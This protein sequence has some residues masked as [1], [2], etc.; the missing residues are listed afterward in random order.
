[1]AIQARQ[2]NV[3][4]FG[5]ILVALWDTLFWVA[6]FGIVVTQMTKFWVFYEGH[7]ER[8]AHLAL[9][10]TIFISDFARRKITPYRQV[11]SL[12]LLFAVLSTS[13]YFWT[14]RLTIIT[15]QGIGT[16]PDI[17]TMGVLVFAA[18]RLSKTTFGWVFPIIAIISILYAMY[19]QLLPGLFHGPDLGWHR[20]GSRFSSEMHGSLLIFT[21]NYLW[22]LVFWGL[23]LSVSGVNIAVMKAANYLARVL[24]AG[25]AMICLVA[26]ASA[27]SFTGA[28]PTNTLI[29]GPIT[30]PAMKRAG[31][32]ANEAAAVEALASHGSAIT[33]PIMGTVAFIMATMLGVSYVNIMIM[34]IPAATL[35]YVGILVY[36]YAHFRRNSYRISAQIDVSA[37]S[38]VSGWMTF[39]SALMG[40]IPVGGLVFLLVALDQTLKQATWWVVIIFAVLAMV[41]RVETNLKVWAEG[42]RRA[43]V[44]ASSVTLV[45]LTIV[46]FNSSIVMTGL[47]NRIAEI[48]YDLAAG[49]L[50]A[51]TF[52]MIVGG[53]LLGAALPGIA[54]FFIM[55]LT[56]V[57]VMAE[58]EI[59]RQISYFVSFYVGTL[60]SITP[61]VA[62]GVL[63]ASTIAQASY[64]GAS[65]VT[66]FMGLPLYFFPFLFVFSPEVVL[67]G[68]DMVRTAYVL[69]IMTIG[70]ISMQFG[71]GGWFIR[72]ITFPERAVMGL[73][74]VIAF[75]GL[76]IYATA[77]QTIGNLI[78]WTS[79]IPFIVPAI[80]IY[81]SRNR[82]VGVSQ[83][84]V[85]ATV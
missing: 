47:E 25:P 21:T 46:I 27:G 12:L 79:P 42:L 34:V 74:P 57:P 1:M 6:V 44:I 38:N 53:V 81:L 50:L 82:I 8:I 49:N 32:T 56:F 66:V 39:R 4:G 40:L 61:P 41:M 60:S 9:A 3:Q 23:L 75:L 78:L 7:G 11:E 45:L 65:K 62:S 54:V 13:W 37:F 14:V 67:Q 52:F 29:T 70:L 72:N 17:I 16:I 48:V 51:A 63:V 69:T 10:F 33:P 15:R 77:S 22:M 36:L 24:R 30:I 76:Y 85:P 2:E 5:R 68:D 59:D 31:Y 26:S 71:M 28:G 35:W 80:E 55:I 83:T 19:S 73:A 64:I 18:I 43:A 84:E 20:V 58:F